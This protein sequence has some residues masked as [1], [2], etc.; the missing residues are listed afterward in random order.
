MGEWLTRCQP[1]S[2]FR[3]ID[4]N[5]LVWDCA[6]RT[7]EE[8]CGADVAWMWGS[9]NTPGVEGAFLHKRGFGYSWIDRQ[10]IVYPSDRVRNGFRGNVQKVCGVNLDR[11]Y[12]VEGCTGVIHHAR[13]GEIDS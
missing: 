2:L 12:A 10:D 1:I 11:S 4:G 9:W 13:T 3:F 7:L 6:D 8:P 5:N